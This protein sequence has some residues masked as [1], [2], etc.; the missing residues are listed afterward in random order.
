MCVCEGVCVCVCVCVCV[1]AKRIEIGDNKIIERE[2][3]SIKSEIIARKRYNKK[4]KKII[5]RQKERDR[6]GEKR[7]ETK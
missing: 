4:T 7:F 2:T 1:F 3:V 6:K 5:K